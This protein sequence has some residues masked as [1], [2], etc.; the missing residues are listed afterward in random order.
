MRIESVCTRL[1]RACAPRATFAAVVLV[2][3][4]V[5]SGAASASGISLG[6]VSVYT[7]NVYIGGDILEVAS[8]PDAQSF[9]ARTQE[10]LAT[11]AA[12]HFPVRAEALAQELVGL[13]PHLIGLQEVV[14]LR[15]N[16]AHGPLPFRDSLEE[17]LLA[18]DRAG[19]RYRVAAVVENLSISVPV[20]VDGDG[21]PDLVSLTD[22]DVIL[23]REDVAAAPVDFP[24]AR[25]SVD[26]CNYVVALPLDLPAPLPDTFLYRGYVGVDAVVDGERYRFVN[27]HLEVQGE[28]GGVDIGFAQVAQAFELLAILD[29]STPRR[30]PVLL[31]GDFNSG[32]DDPLPA[33][34]AQIRAAAYRDLWTSSWHPRRDRDGFTC[35]QAPALDNEVSLLDERIDL[36]FVRNNLG[37]L[38]FSFVGPVSAVVVGDEPLDLEQPRWSSDHAGPW[39]TLWAI[40]VFE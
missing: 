37:L 30:R 17:L 20:D 3:S 15:L 4:M 35:C 38:P 9:L 23:V 13:E 26:G 40:P 18:L 28:L 6:R 32:P 24:C 19:L 16:G 5:A 2:V 11:M 21:A 12:T 10:L 39:A 33:P 27:T 14:D 8:A 34:Y 31:V 1:C 29:E 7:R 22:R 25:P 36:L